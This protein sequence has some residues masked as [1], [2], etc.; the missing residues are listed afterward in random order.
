VAENKRVLVIDDVASVLQVVK[1]ALNDFDIDLITAADGGSGLA[2]AQQLKPDLILLDLALPVLNG[3]DVLAALKAE[4]ATVDIP[5]VIITAHGESGAASEAR[6]MGADAFIAK[7]FRP[8][9]LRRAVEARLTD[10]SAAA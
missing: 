1:A 10:D 2:L 3:W 7:P 9:E 8:A 5:I 6:E 4:R